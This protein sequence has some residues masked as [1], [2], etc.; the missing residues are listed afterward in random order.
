[1]MFTEAMIEEKLKNYNRL[2]EQITLLEYEI[3]HPIKLSSSEVLNA[4]A[5]VKSKNGVSIKHTD[6][7]HDRVAHLATH[8]REMAEKMSE[9]ANDA[10]VQEWNR[11]MEEALRLEKYVSLLPEVCQVVLCAVY[12]ERKSWH[13]I[14]CE[15]G[16]SRRTLV[17][18]KNL[19]IQNLVE[20]YC[21]TERFCAR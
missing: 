15:T 10:V 18:K 7:G 8:Y 16:I 11:L 20:M 2:R 19:G 14:E 13:E 17:R 1:M 12:I 6:T 5:Y 9:E 3:T 4:L 21:Y